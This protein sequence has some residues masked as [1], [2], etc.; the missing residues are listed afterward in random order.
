MPPSLASNRF[1]WQFVFPT[2]IVT[3]LPR[4]NPIYP[5]SSQVTNITRL[6]VL[7]LINFCYILQ[8]QTTWS[9]FS[10]RRW[11]CLPIFASRDFQSIHF[12]NHHWKFYSN[13]RYSW[14]H[15]KNSFFSL[16]E[17]V[18]STQ[19]IVWDVRRESLPVVQLQKHYSMHPSQCYITLEWLPILKS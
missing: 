13:L 11:T 19:H 6:V 10:R 14:N 18:Q 8:P 12:W 3:L 5:T 17:T 4:L 15:I 9:N 1:R 2:K 16:W 7:C